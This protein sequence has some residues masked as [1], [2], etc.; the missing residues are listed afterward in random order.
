M[1]TTAEVVDLLNRWAAA[2]Q[3]NDAAALESVLDADF[4]GV[5]PVGFVLTRD[6]WLV[7]F[8]NGLH[9][10]AFAVQ[11]PQV[12]E[13][14]DTAA[15]IAVL[16]QQTKFHGNDN[17]GQ[18]RLSLVAVRRDDQWRL[19]GVHIGMLQQPPAQPTEG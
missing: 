13:F 17:S 10:D 6:Q 4:V 12:R 7:R 19:A 14:G 15:V 11:D 3:A 18:F 5:G 9:N 1:S 2:E 16:D 8:D